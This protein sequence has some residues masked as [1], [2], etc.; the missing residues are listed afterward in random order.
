MPA[1]TA[2]AS[3]AVSPTPETVTQSYGTI[4]DG[5]VGN[6]LLVL[7]TTTARGPVNNWNIFHFYKKEDAWRV[8]R[9]ERPTGTPLDALTT[10]AAKDQKEIVPT[11]EAIEALKAKLP[12]LTAL[13]ENQTFRVVVMR[14]AD[15]F[16]AESPPESKDG[17][18]SIEILDQ[19]S[20]NVVSAVQ[21][22]AKDVQANRITGDSHA[23]TI[24][25][26]GMS[27]IPMQMSGTFKLY[28]LN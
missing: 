11:R 2:V 3:P 6:W 20:G 19:T 7:Q 28:R 26:T 4:P 25:A 17:K 21:M 16:V 10:E 14:A 13:P 24:A 1:P 8:Q 18:F 15:H 27:V 22:Y 5:L 23:T 12:Q 9:Y